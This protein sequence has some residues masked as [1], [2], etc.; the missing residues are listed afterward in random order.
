MI[1]PF[2]IGLVSLAIGFVLLFLGL[3]RGGVSP[4]FLQFEAAVILYPPIVMVFV[5][6]GVAELLTAYYQ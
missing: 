4:R 3:P 5:A 2:L 1:Q 6:A